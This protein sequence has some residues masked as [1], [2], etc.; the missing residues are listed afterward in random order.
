M[1]IKREDFNVSINTKMNLIEVLKMHLNTGNVLN[2]I[3]TEPQ[4]KVALNIIE[5]SNK[6]TDEQLSVILDPKLSA[7]KM[8]LAKMAFI[9]GL[10]DAQV[11]AVLKSQQPKEMLKYFAFQNDLYK[12][13]SAS[14]FEGDTFSEIPVG[15]S[16]SF[17]CG[18]TFD[19]IDATHPRK[20]DIN[21]IFLDK[22]PDANVKA[23]D[24][25]EDFIQF[26]IDEHSSTK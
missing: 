25:F 22:F 2:Q 6:F 5:K 3:Y 14:D 4:L 10:T 17:N 9:E 12:A 24:S 23:F 1:D 8:N 13:P 26:M 16:N 21:K 20:I 18:D 7:P 15:K 11:N 19:Y